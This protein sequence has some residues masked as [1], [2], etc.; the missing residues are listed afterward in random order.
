MSFTHTV[1]GMAV[2]GA[3]VEAARFQVQVFGKLPASVVAVA[4]GSQASSC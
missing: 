2:E 1:S 4:S 3:E